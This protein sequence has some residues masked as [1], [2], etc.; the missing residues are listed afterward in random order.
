MIMVK[1]GSLSR[2]T[3]G[4][5]GSGRRE[6]AHS[7]LAPVDT[8][9]GGHEGDLRIDR[10]GAARSAANT[11]EESGRP[12]RRSPK[13]DAPL[14][15][16]GRTV[17]GLTH[18]VVLCGIVG[19]LVWQVIAFASRS[20]D[21]FATIV[22]APLH[23][24]RSPVDGLFVAHKHMP[25]GTHVTKGQF[26]GWIRSPQ[27]DADI[28]RTQ[29]KLDVLKR[30]KLLLEQRGSESH[31]P[32]ARPESD[33]EFRQCAAEIVA[34][35]SD[36]GRLLRMKRKLRAVSPVTGQISNG[37]FSGSKA[38][39][40]NDTVAFVWPDN[41]ELLV[42]VKAPLKAIHR[43]IQADHVEARFSTVG[44]QASV[45][46]RPIAGSLRVFTLDRGAAKKKELW[47]TLQCRPISIPDSVAY[48]G[49]IG[50]L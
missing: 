27:L 3:N 15:S 24:V 2:N 21:A 28:Q 26:L 20:K 34:M 38:V 1:A 18:A 40:T 41:G 46:A 8:P 49:P 16:A 33:R 23:E 30:R 50:V 31:H 42:E 29:R 7:F 5:R 19:L 4:E 17:I 37:G 9:P 32:L 48:P 13:P 47:G 39:K 43:L 22:A 35:E 44:G 6:E 11:S 45:T 12:G 25:N 14:R 36:L 10:Q